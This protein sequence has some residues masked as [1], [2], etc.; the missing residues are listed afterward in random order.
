MKTVV[1]FLLVAVGIF[2]TGCA[3]GPEKTPGNSFNISIYK[4]V[5]SQDNTGKIIDEGLS[6]WKAFSVL[7]SQV[8]DLPEWGNE[9]YAYESQ[10]YSIS[11]NGYSEFTI[12][13]YKEQKQ[14]RRQILPKTDLMHIVRER[15]KKNVI[16]IYN[17]EDN[18]KNFDVEGMEKYREMYC[19]TYSESFDV[20]PIGEYLKERIPAAKFEFY[21]DSEMSSLL[22]S[23]YKNERERWYGGSFRLLNSAKIYIKEA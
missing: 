13:D 14:I 15:R 5:L 20:T 1:L 6:L 19:E 16:F 17:G 9:R 10:T 4:R 23:Y 21:F 3:Q 18:S 12:Y 11:E 22:T 7:K 8:Y 2:C